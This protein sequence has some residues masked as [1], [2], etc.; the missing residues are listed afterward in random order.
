MQLA[1]KPEVQ[2]CGGN[3]ENELAVIDFL[4]D[5]N[6]MYGAIRHRFEAINYFRFQ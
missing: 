5:F 2:M 1:I 6:I 4:F 3:R